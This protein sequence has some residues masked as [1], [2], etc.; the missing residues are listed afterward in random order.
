LAVEL[1]GPHADRFLPATVGPTLFASIRRANF[2][3]S[4]VERRNAFAAL[5]ELT[6]PAGPQG[7]CQLWSWYEFPS[8]ERPLRRLNLGSWIVDL[9]GATGQLPSLI[10]QLASHSR[11]NDSQVSDPQIRALL[12]EATAAHQNDTSLSALLSAAQNRLGP[13]PPV[14][15][16]AL[17]RELDPDLYVLGVLLRNSGI[18]ILSTG[19]AVRRLDDMPPTPFCMVGIRA[20]APQF[21][22]AALRRRHSQPF[23]ALAFHQMR[24]LVDLD[25]TNLAIGDT[26]L[27][28]FHELTK[29]TTLRL[30]GTD[31]T[32]N[33]LTKLLPLKK[34]LRTLSLQR[35]DVTP[36]AIESMRA[37]L[38]DCEIVPP[39]PDASGVKL[40]GISAD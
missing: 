35:T 8:A 33:G 40:D 21:Q 6:F 14:W 20:N 25:L 31:V 11:G 28:K 3:W 37:A 27:E 2:H 12:L 26:A 15:T 38:P 30:D 13:N 23:Q 39:S 16:E 5:L 19:E 1:R 17:V 4:A 24:Q 7:P 34:S 18:G 32:D 9:A 29:L 36:A 10:E 22:D